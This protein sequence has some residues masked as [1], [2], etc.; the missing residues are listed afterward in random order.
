M[1]IELNKHLPELS[2]QIQLTEK[3]NKIPLQDKIKVG[4]FF[5]F[6][7][8]SQATWVLGLKCKLK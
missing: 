6:C 4:A 1:K 2:C 7:K 3:R 8:K 5:L